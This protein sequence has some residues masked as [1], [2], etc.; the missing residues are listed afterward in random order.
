MAGQN[1]RLFSVDG[2][3][4]NDVW[5][6]GRYFVGTAQQTLVLHWNG[7]AWSQVNTPPGVLQSITAI[8]LDDVWAVGYTDTQPHA[9]LTM[10]WDGTQWSVVPSPNLGTSDNY[11]ESVSAVSSNDVWAVGW[12]SGGSATLVLHWNGTEWTQSP[13]P[14]IT[15]SLTGVSAL[16]SNDVWAVGDAGLPGPPIMH[17][18]GTSW[19]TVY[20]PPPAPTSAT[21]YYDVAA[22]S[23]NEVWLAGFR[24]P[25][26]FNSRTLIMRHMGTCD[27]VTPTA[28]ATATTTAIA[29][30]TPTPTVAAT[31]TIPRTPSATPSGITTRASTPTRTATS[32]A[33]A[34]RTSVA[35]PT[36]CTIAFSDVPTDNTFYPFVRCLACRGIINGY[37]DGTFRPNNY[38]TRGQLAKIVSLSAGF[39]EPV[40]GQ[41][42]ED[43]APGST[44]YDYVERLA[45][46]EVMGG[47]QCGIDPAEPCGPGNRPYFR[48]NAG[49]TRGQLTKIVSNAAAFNDTIPA[50]QHNFTDVPEGSTFHLYVERLLLNRSGVM[51]GYSCGGTAEP[52][53]P[54]NHPYFRPG[55]PL[56]R[57][58]T[59]KIVANT[60]FPGCGT[61]GR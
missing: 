52:C 11:L 5:A 25:T 33:S 14:G 1:A 34:T 21:I 13:T 30:S 61:P 26:P 16:A 57:G 48:P 10:H 17:W 42:F 54:E 7:I 15:A 31:A 39:T 4:S 45:S 59:A 22:I 32:A 50:G 46:H 36:A 19:T 53:D 38:V 2:T 12:Y 49:A 20:G 27:P 40:S 51:S 24:G 47:Y 18:D 44:F 6:V 23:S 29:T 58:Q 37:P 60:F 3:A 28:T 56:T 35:T 9:T 41:T 8:S 55:N 43:V